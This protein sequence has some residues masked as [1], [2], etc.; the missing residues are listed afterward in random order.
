MS[1]IALGQGGNVGT[2]QEKRAGSVEPPLCHRALAGS[3]TNYRTTI[4]FISQISLFFKGFPHW[5]I[6]LLCKLFQSGIVFGFDF[7]RF[8]GYTLFSPAFNLDNGARGA[9]Y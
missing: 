8:F 4:L 1:E 3:G 9:L 2:R 6:N 7:C 5:K